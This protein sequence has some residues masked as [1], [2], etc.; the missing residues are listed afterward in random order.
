M[1]LKQEL[2][3]IIAKCLTQEEA[4]RFYDKLNIVELPMLQGLWKGQEL[5]TGYPKEGILSGCGWYGKKFEGIDEVHPLVFEASGHR[6][7]YINPRLVPLKIPF[8]KIPKSMVSI[9]FL[10]LKPF[11]ITKKSKAR[12]RMVYYRGK[13]SAGMVYDQLPIIDV[14][15]K[16]DDNT[17]MGVMDFKGSPSKNNFFFVLERVK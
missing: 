12:L 6:L 2:E 11:I 5:R 3:D 15:R 13:V 8:E 9:L 16:V 10:L 17:V 7:Y 14:F 1:E 4:F